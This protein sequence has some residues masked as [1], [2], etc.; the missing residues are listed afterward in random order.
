[1]ERV[2]Q[3]ILTLLLLLLSFTMIVPFIYVLAI[4]FSDSSNYI[5]GGFMLF[6]K[7]FSWEAYDYVLSGQG[8]LNAFK[9]SLFI[10]CIGVPLS[11]GISSMM[12]YML[13]KKTLPG[14]KWILNLVIFTMLFSP[15]LIPNY[16][17]IDKLN[18]ID[19][20]WSLILPGLVGAWTL[21][22]MKSFFQELPSEIEESAKID[23]CNDLTIF[24]RIILPLSKAM[25]AAFT[26]FAAVAYWNTFF[27]AIMYITTP[28]KWPLQVF[29]QQIVVQ[30]NVNEFTDSGVDMTR[31]QQINPEIVKMTAVMVVTAPILA[32]YPFLQKYFA[33]GVLIGSVKG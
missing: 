6:P 11:I 24:F 7:D 13:A 23:G 30:A 22:V 17:L 10:T 19:S 2:Y 5:S 21:L 15:G 29:L 33:K 16:L 12:A 1:M 26:L 18:L 20:W 25:L 4:S 3:G 8:F 32:L 27:S 28:E 14:R 9:A 31:N